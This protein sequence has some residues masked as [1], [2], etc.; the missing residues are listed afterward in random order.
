MALARDSLE[1]LVPDALAA[2]DVTG[3]DALALH[4]E[5]YDFAARWARPGRLLDI[6]CGVGYGTQRL[7]ERVG[8]AREVVGVDVS[9]EAIEHARARYAHPLA[10]Y[11][12]A[13]AMGFADAEGFDT[14]VSLETL[15]HL[16]E[17]AGFVARVAG[18]LRPRGVL[19][20][21]VPTTPSVDVNPHHLHDF[22]A[23]SFRRLL[24]R[25]G[26]RELAALEQAQPVPLAAVLGRG[27]LRLADRREG[28]PA[29]YLA[30]PGALARRVYA[31]LRYGLANRYLTLVC[32]RP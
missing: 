8:G 7:A 31:T 12:A 20:A 28:L 9:A 19:V 2:S 17:P 22:S 26:L 10:R 11:E 23:A 5:R 15:E 29:W 13:D 6:A 25:V 18:L 21:S 3:R 1:R 30:H 4:L 27:E 14:I 16:P 32:E 24:A